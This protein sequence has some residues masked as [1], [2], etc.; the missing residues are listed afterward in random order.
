MFDIFVESAAEEPLTPTASSVMPE[1]T[2]SD[3]IAIQLALRASANARRVLLVDCDDEYS[4][5][6][7][8]HLQGQGH[9]VRECN[10][11]QDA[12]S[13]IASDNSGFDVVIISEESS[14]M[15]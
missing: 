6:L 8:V 13:L 14:E 5:S 1:R 4:K 12:L 11:G 2:L 15:R 10:N 9:I 7:S 3:E